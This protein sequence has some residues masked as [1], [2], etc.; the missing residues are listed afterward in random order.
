MLLV[1]L[2]LLIYLAVTGLLRLWLRF[3]LLTL[4]SAGYLLYMLLRITR[5]CC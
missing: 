3:G 2:F 4:L 5:Y 1:I